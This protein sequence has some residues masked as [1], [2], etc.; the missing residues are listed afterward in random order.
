MAD[1]ITRAKKHQETFNEGKPKGYRDGKPYAHILH[2]DNDSAY[3]KWKAIKKYGL[4]DKVK[5]LA[6]ADDYFVQHLQTC[7]HHLTSSQIMCYNFFRPLKEIPEKLAAVFS[8]LGAKR[9]QAPECYFEYAP[10]NKEK[11]NFDFYIKGQDAHIAC[12]IKY[13][14]NCFNKKCGAKPQKW[15]ER[16]KMYQNL[17][18]NTLWLWNDKVH[19]DIPTF[20]DQCINN[21]YQLFRNALSADTENSYT[22]FI[23]PEGRK[24]LK[25]S[26]VKFVNEYMSDEGKK[27][28]IFLSWEKLIDAAR[29]EY[30]DMQK[31]FDDFNARYLDFS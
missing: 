3:S 5:P 1:F 17:V 19:N 24:N 11:T 22:F 29:E 18:N 16:R 28:V 25:N 12:E 8:R 2:I 9:I 10:D 30:S 7:A 4:L 23:C 14:E 6:E 21:H 26:Y 13:T 31:F 20:V 27:H 15:D